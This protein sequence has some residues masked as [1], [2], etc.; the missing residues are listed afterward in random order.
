MS[1]MSDRSRGLLFAASAALI[2]CFFILLS[3]LSARADFNGFDLGFLRFSAA[4][5]SVLPIL[6]LRGKGP[7]FAGV[8]PARAVVLALFGG[9]GFS[10]LA[11]TGFMFAPAAHAAVLMT[12]ILPL[13]TALVAL[14]ILG[15]A[16]SR[17]KALGLAAIMAG[18]AL[19]GVHSIS[20]A[21]PNAWIG[22]ICFPLAAVSWAFFTSYTRKW[23]V[24]AMDSTIVVVLVCCAVYVPG[25]LLWAPKKLM[26]APLSTI[27]LTAFFQGTIA[28][29]VSM[30]CFN[31]A[32][33]AL[34]PTRTTMI[35]ALA[36]GLSSLIAVP[37]LGEPL[38][39][40]L[41]LGLVAVTAGM[42]IG[43]TGGTPRVA[44]PA[45]AAT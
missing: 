23:K 31:R 35:T 28:L 2:W 1:K 17:R 13:P 9:A 27:L 4:A 33:A 10:G 14:V 18:V 12:G 11:Y 32:V 37:L 41:V 5:L 7:H 45:P 16:I 15:E 24:G 3:R 21:P 25:Y 22:D 43:V 36:P 20:D 26:A 29:V 19:V 39:L 6:L 30:W 38:S 40:L 42:L 34:G 44:M 8:T